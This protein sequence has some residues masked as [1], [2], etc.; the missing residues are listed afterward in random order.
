MTN[1]V[2]SCRVD[3]CIIDSTMDMEFKKCVTQ[4]DKEHADR[5]NLCPYL[6]IQSES[7]FKKGD[8]WKKFGEIID[9]SKQK[10]KDKLF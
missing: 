7:Y 8:V 4:N 10:G 1:L 6:S 9:K 2:L 3:K 5:L